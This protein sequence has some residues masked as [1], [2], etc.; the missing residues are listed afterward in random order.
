MSKPRPAPFLIADHPALDFLN[1]TA[2]PWG[3]PIEW[4]SNGSDLLDWLECAG[5]VDGETVQCL[6]SREDFDSLDEIAQQARELREWFRQ[7]VN[8]HAGYQIVS[9][10]ITE[11]EPLNDLLA[12]DVAF[13]Q[14]EVDETHNNKVSGLVCTKHRHWNHPQHLL[15][16]LAEAICECVCNVDFVLVRR[17][18]N[19]SC[20]LWF[21]DTTKSHIRRWCSMSVCGNR[22]KAS[23]YRARAKKVLSPKSANQKLFKKSD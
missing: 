23:A 14:I 12:R 18:E 11:L 16:P 15:Q 17:C 19:P 9:S 1:S 20:T 4:L 6:R 22:A 2:S 13:L 8:R 5:M 7:F 3:T 10:A 21:H